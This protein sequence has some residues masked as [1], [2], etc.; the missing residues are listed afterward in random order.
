VSIKD[1][2]AVPPLADWRW[3]VRE[4]VREPDPHDLEH[5]LQDCQALTSQFTA[6]A[7]VLQVWLKVNDGQLAPPL[8]GWT[9]TCLD[10]ICWPDP[11]CTE[12]SP[13]ADH[14]ETLQ[15]MGQAVTLQTRVSWVDGQTAPLFDAAS[16]IVLVRDWEPLQQ[17]LEQTD[18]ELQLVVMQS[19][20][21]CCALHGSDCN[22]AGQATPLFAA[23][24]M[25][26]RDRTLLP[27]PNDCEHCCHCP[28]AETKQLT[29]HGF[30][31]Q[32]SLLVVDSHGTPQTGPLG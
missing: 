11:H 20:G 13:K 26:L 28:H 19:V 29:G 10:L 18:H 16:V 5:T 27:P 3:T 7:C 21:H 32:D 30:E 14:V 2:H 24:V 17:L 1:G 22:N 12:H 25:T 8:L 15:S 9:S 23:A 6:H 4:R 31:L